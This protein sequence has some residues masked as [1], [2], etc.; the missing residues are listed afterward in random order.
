MRGR[1]IIYIFLI[2]ILVVMGYFGFRI[3]VRS[4]IGLSLAGIVFLV[5]NYFAHSEK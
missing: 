3:G 5:Y 1:A 4:L 2:G